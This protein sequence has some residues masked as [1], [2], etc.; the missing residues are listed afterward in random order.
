MV[1]PTGAKNGDVLLNHDINALYA[2][3]GNIYML[4]FSMFERFFDSSHECR[5]ISDFKLRC[6]YVRAGL[7][8]L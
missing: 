1:S 8:D 5:I 3:W 6:N 2:V 4:S 7:T